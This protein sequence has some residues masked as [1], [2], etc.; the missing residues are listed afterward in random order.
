MDDY[1]YE[2]MLADMVQKDSSI[3]TKL[4]KWLSAHPEMK[5]NGFAQLNFLYENS[6]YDE[7]WANRYPVLKVF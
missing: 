5:N 3:K 2:D 1:V 6:I 7:P 4:D